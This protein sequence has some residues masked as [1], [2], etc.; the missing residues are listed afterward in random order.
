[1]HS[2]TLSLREETTGGDSD[3]RKQT[4]LKSKIQSMRLIY[5]YMLH[6]TMNTDTETTV[7]LA[8]KTLQQLKSLGRKGETYNDIIIRL[9]NEISREKIIARQYERLEEKDKIIRLEGT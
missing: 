5:Y 1:M 3:C 4:C 2:G 6:R 8:G 7:Q 9:I